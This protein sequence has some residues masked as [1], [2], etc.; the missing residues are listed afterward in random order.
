MKHVIKEVNSVSADRSPLLVVNGS[1]A[2]AKRCASRSQVFKGT[3]L[4]IENTRGL[5]LAYKIYLLER[6]KRDNQKP[7]R[8]KQ[9]IELDKIS[10]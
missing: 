7:T 6:W 9:I 5:M 3:I 4:K 8:Y 2:S 10:F 1:L